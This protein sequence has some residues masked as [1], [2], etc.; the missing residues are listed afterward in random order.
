MVQI[1]D[2]TKLGDSAVLAYPHYKT[3][4]INRTMTDAAADVAYTGFGFT[5]RLLVIHAVG[6]GASATND[7]RSLG[8]ADTAGE[9]NNDSNFIS[10]ENGL[11][12]ASGQQ[13]VRYYSATSVGV[14]CHVESFDSDGFTLG[15]GK[16]G[17]PSGNIACMCMAFA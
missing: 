11:Y 7:E 9:F 6:G 4:R 15:W 8:W 10:S 13:I 2:L 3:L 16:Q 5:P 1:G 12:V 14:F 17:A